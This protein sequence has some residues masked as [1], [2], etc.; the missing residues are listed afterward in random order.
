MKSKHHLDSDRIVDLAWQL[1]RGDLPRQSELRIAREDLFRTHLF[2]VRSACKATAVA[3]RLVAAMVAGRMDDERRL[4]SAQRLLVELA[5]DEDSLIED[6]FVAF[7]TTAQATE[8][9][10]LGKRAT[11]KQK[12]ALRAIDDPEAR[13]RYSRLVREGA[14]ADVKV[15]LAMPLA[16]RRRLA[17]VLFGVCT[18]VWMSIVLCGMLSIGPMD[19]GNLVGYVVLTTVM[20]VWLGRGQL[21]QVRDD[22]KAAEVASM[23][24]RPKFRRPLRHD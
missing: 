9:H 5:A 8:D 11:V 22:E 15:G 17:S 6:V 2:H 18:A 13:A 21:S 4:L 19:I 10:L 3:R 7:V 16:K 12:V 1:S 24:L 20:S 23:G 14:V